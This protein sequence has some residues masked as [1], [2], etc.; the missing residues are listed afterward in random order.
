MRTIREYAEHCNKT[1]GDNISEELIKNA[2]IRL[3]AIKDL[4]STMDTEEK[5][6]YA[7]TLAASIGDERL[8]FHQ[9]HLIFEDGNLNVDDDE[10]MYWTI[11][12]Q[13]TSS[14]MGQYP[15]AKKF[16]LAMTMLVAILQASDWKTRVKI[17]IAFCP[18]PNSYFEWFDGTD[19]DNEYGLRKLSKEIR[20]EDL[21][22]EVRH[23]LED[24][25]IG[26][27]LSMF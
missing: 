18:D 1:Y 15:K 2:E 5:L 7:Y 22:E 4:V 24:L 6:R 13:G 17:A 23:E 25:K 21:K 8:L 11:C 9:T 19:G 20:Y 3:K 14:K 27:D 26:G 16:D 12:Q 10:D